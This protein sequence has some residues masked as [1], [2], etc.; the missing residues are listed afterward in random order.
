L[1]LFLELALIRWCSANVIYLGYFANFVLLACFLGIGVGFLSARRDWNLFRFAPLSLFGLMTFVLLA[2]TELTLPDHSERVFFGFERL[3]DSLLPPWLTLALLF[4]GTTGV[5]TTISQETGRCFRHFK[6]LEA[7]SVDILGSLV[8]IL[9]FTGVSFLQAPAWSWFLVVGAAFVFLVWDHKDPKVR[10]AA[11][12]AAVGCAALAWMSQ[13]NL[14][15]DEHRW[16]PYQLVT[17]KQDADKPELHHLGVNRIPHQTT[18]PVDYKLPSY[19][20]TYS[21]AAEHGLDHFKRAL[22]IGSGSGTDVAYA[23]AHGVEEIDAVEIDPVIAEYGRTYHP[24][25]P[26]VDERVSLII[27]DGR[28]VL[29]RSHARYDLIIFALPDSLALLSSYSSLRL[30]SFL[31]TRES[32]EAAHRALAPGGMLVMYNAYRTGDIVDRL[33]TLMHETFERWPVIHGTR[34][35]AVTVMA[36][37]SSVGSVER[38]SAVEQPSP[39]VPTDDWPFL[40]MVEKSVPLLYLLPLALILLFSSVL[41]WRVG[42]RSSFQGYHVTFFFM[43]AAFLLLETKS[44]VQFSLLFGAT[45]LTNALVFAAVLTMVLIANLIIMWRRPRRVWPLYVLLAVSL[46]LG[47][48]IN[49]TELASIGSGGLRY[50]AAAGL[51]FS[52]IFLAN[53][54]FSSTFAGSD[55]A[56]VS[57]GWNLMGAML[58]GTF[59]YAS[60]AMG[61]QKLAI[62]VAIFYALAFGAFWLWARKEP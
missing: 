49:P 51:I 62:I 42:P 18:F 28:N 58:G 55:N 5:F 22:V 36:V 1:T 12:V 19:E 34:E 41:V 40:Y 31:F 54:I 46:F 26:Y 47:W 3:T 56:D 39:L 37:G 11:I 50:L 9:L 52:P 27:D 43:G 29:E 8:G 48:Y 7:Y 32:I 24:D 61:Y 13:L 35:G 17:V 4:A 20:K 23:L 33:A 30:E 25:G 53:L 57:F 44:I 45:W 60:L 21:I 6:A 59:E 2:Q 10:R 14:A 38:P 16:S 15:S